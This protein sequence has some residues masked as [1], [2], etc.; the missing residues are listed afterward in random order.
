MFLGQPDRNCPH[1][2]TPLHAFPRS[3]HCRF[4]LAGLP[5]GALPVPRSS[6]LSRGWCSGAP[7][8]VQ[9]GLAQST[10]CLQ[11]SSEYGR[12]AGAVVALHFRRSACPF[13]A[14]ASPQKAHGEGMHCWKGRTPAP[15]RTTWH[16]VGLPSGLTR[17]RYRGPSFGC[18]PVS[19]ADSRALAGCAQGWIWLLLWL[20]GNGICQC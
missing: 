5:E 15:A 13:P 19:P 4:L 8:L 7:I 9:L 2:I 10:M 16:M 1:G 11:V 12:L 17:L 14:A 3:L 20:P 6:V 18:P